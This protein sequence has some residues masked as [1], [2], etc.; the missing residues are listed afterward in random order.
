MSRLPLIFWALCWILALGASAACGFWGAPPAV[1]NEPDCPSP[2]L[3]DVRPRHNLGRLGTVTRD[4]Y[5]VWL[6]AAGEPGYIVPLGMRLM[7]PAVLPGY[8]LPD[9]APLLN[10]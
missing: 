1:I 9:C 2:F 10:P 7:V 6:N 8:P 5:P 3:M 4:G